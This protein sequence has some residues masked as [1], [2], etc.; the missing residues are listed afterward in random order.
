[1][2]ETSFLQS[3][4]RLFAYYR[5]LGE[6]T[7]EQVNDDALFRQPGPRS[8]SI[9]VIVKHLSGNMLSR[10]TDF[11]TTDGEKPW[12]QRDDEFVGDIS[13]RQEMLQRWDAG[14]DS[15][16]QVLDALDPD[17]LVRIVYIR[18]EGHTVT[19]AIHRHLTHYA[20]HVG[21]I[22]YLGR[23]YAG[24]NWQSLTI[25]LDASKEFNE[26]MFGKTKQRKHFTDPDR[27]Q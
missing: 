20:Y 21:Q 27:D 22:V 23:L 17:D 6:R 18:N 16:T 4:S 2:P 1:M 25:P 8:N 14:W 9:A 10:W 15:V 19:E 7:F 13:S 24:E 11:L 3:T 5:S 26:Q 12:R